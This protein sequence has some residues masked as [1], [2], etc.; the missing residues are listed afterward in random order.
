MVALKRC[1]ALTLL[2]IALTFLGTSGSWHISADDPDA[3]L[4]VAHDH[5]AHHARFTDAGSHE[6]PSHCAICHWLQSFR[7]DSVRAGGI[8][9]AAE[10][11]GRAGAVDLEAAST[12]DL[13]SLPP[14]AP[15]V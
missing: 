7:S 14:R 4:L 2:L 1:K 10:Q 11:V 5:S 9:F 6:A 12:A 13:L 8:R 3:P 15:P